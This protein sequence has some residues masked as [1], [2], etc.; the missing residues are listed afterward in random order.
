MVSLRRTLD[1]MSVMVGS[2]SSVPLSASCLVNRA[3]MLSLVERARAELPA[4]LDEATALLVAHQEVL[5]DAEREGEQLLQEAR[6]RAEAMVEETVIV[7]SAQARAEA[8][9]HA[10]RTEAT[11]LLRSA[12][13]YCDRRLAVFENDLDGALA[14]VRRGRD[15]LRERSE[16]DSFAQEVGLADAADAV[17]A[18]AAAEREREREFDRES[19]PERGAVDVPEQ[20]G[21]RDGHADDHDQAPRRVIDLT[22]VEP[23]GLGPGRSLQ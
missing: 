10:A 8:I 15:R 17:D 2:A 22:A 19:E 7:A 14:Q 12:D 4:E 21:S 11:R 18:A 9:L 16:L 20:G 13:D 6:S 3:E 23:A 5:D 1:A